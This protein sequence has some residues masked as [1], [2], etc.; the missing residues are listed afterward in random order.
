ML[1]RHS[2]AEAMRGDLS[3]KAELLANLQAVFF[4]EF[5][6]R[7]QYLCLLLF[8]PL[9]SLAKKPKIIGQCLFYILSKLFYIAVF[10][11]IV[12][13]DFAFF[14]VKVKLL[15]KLCEVFFFL[16][17]DKV[18]ELLLDSIAVVVAIWRKCAYK[19]VNK[20]FF[21]SQL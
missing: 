2:K 13:K 18:C 20:I 8:A 14:F 21:A 4:I 5:P 17:G 16:C 1:V 7:L 12:C 3:R 11:A 6:K 9:S 15:Y 19:C 10:E